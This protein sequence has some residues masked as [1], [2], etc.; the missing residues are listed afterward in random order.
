MFLRAKKR[1]KDGKLHHYWSIVEN[2]RTACGRVVQRHVLYL[3]EINDSQ[4]ESWCRTIEILEHGQVR[5]TQ[6]ALYPGGRRA[7][8]LD[9]EVIH[10]RMADVELHR[11]RQWGACWLAC[12]LWSWLKLDSFWLE[13]LPPSREGTRWKNVLQTLVCYRLISPGS[14]WKF[15]SCQRH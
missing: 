12:E 3:G 5:P 11:P 14:E 13:K 7:A 10:V 9:C 8:A 4:M 6:V 15:G 2:R 1:L